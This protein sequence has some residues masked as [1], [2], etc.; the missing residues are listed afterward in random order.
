MTNIIELK[1]K[2]RRKKITIESALEQ[3][4]AAKPREVIVLANSEDGKE[5]LYFHTGATNERALWLL[6]QIRIMLVT[7]ELEE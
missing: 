4:I 2:G 5:I 3:V 1:P 6:E 7:G